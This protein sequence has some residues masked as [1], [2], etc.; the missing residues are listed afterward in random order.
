MT[1]HTFSSNKMELGAKLGAILQD[2]QKRAELVESPKTT[3]ARIGANSDLTILADTADT[4]HILIPAEVDAAR[5]AAEDE[6]YFEE[7]G[8]QALGVCMYD[9]IPE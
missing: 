4:V 6:A 1:Q 2:P 7:L 3:L 5:V 9:D 8:R